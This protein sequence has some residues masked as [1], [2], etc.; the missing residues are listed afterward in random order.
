VPTALWTC[1]ISYPIG[2]LCP[3]GELNRKVN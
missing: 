1:M 3:Q 2:Y